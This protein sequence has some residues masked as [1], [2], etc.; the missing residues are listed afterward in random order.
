M[1]SCRTFSRTKCMS[2]SMWLVRECW[3]ELVKRRNIFLFR[4]LIQSSIQGCISNKDSPAASTGEYIKEQA[5]H[6]EDTKQFMMGNA[7]VLCL[8]LSVV[9]RPP[10][11]P[12]PKENNKINN[13]DKLQWWVVTQLS[14][15]LDKL[16]LI[17][18][19]YLKIKLWQM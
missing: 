13:Y 9:L 16:Q 3:I 10:N 5:N 12:N 8:F 18:L 19:K 6:C 2:N 1:R 14:R 7:Y 4:G 17:K 15:I 11:L